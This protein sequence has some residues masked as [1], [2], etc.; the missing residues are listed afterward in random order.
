MGTAAL[1]CENGRFEAPHKV[2]F[3]PPAQ[4]KPQTQQ[5]EMCSYI[6]LQLPTL[7]QGKVER[8]STGGSAHQSLAR[9]WCA[10]DKNNPTTTVQPHL[11]S[12]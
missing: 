1:S 5:P 6:L 11:N 10:Q 9:V 7:Q 12:H 3:R 8:V 4:T 2:F